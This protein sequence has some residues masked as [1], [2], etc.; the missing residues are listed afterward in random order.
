ML[1]CVIYLKIYVSREY[2]GRIYCSIAQSCPTNCFATPWIVAHQIS[3]FTRFPRQQYW[4]GLPFPSPGDL[5][6]PGIEPTSPALA[7]G[8]FTATTVLTVNIS[9]C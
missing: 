4:S 2:N 8:V 9:G 7:G 1:F 3:L 6:D 5:P